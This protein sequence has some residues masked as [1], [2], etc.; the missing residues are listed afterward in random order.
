MMPLQ[1]N[2][3]THLQPSRTPIYSPPFSPAF[4][5]FQP[6]VML[7]SG[8]GGAQLPAIPLRAFHGWRRAGD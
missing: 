5:P 3:S 6:L 8:G 2:I 1:P 4:W 7:I